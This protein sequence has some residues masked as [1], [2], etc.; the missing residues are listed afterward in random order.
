MMM[1]HIM[2]AFHAVEKPFIGTPKPVVTSRSI[3]LECCCY[4]E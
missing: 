2:I 1:T 3:S 4:D